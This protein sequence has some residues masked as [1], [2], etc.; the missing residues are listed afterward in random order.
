MIITSL[1]V[2]LITADAADNGNGIGVTNAAHTENNTDFCNYKIE[3]Y[4]NGTKV[5]GAPEFTINDS[6]N[7]A[8]YVG[9]NGYFELIKDRSIEFTSSNDFKNYIDE[10]RIDEVRIT[11]V[12]SDNFSDHQAATSSNPNS[13][14][15]YS[16]ATGTNANLLVDNT[17]PENPVTDQHTI[18]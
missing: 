2:N 12:A 13:Y 14:E 1:P 8:V 7:S 10:N 9:S 15:L 18:V 5:T 3:F 17:D 11:F 6:T 4:K 16:S